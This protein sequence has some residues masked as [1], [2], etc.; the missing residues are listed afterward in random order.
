[1]AYWKIVGDPDAYEGGSDPS[2]DVTHGYLFTL[3]GEAD[4]RS[5]IRVEAAKGAGELS[6]WNARDAV[7]DVLV[8]RYPP[9]RLVMGTSGIFWPDDRCPICGRPVPFTGTSQLGADARAATFA[10]EWGK[11][12]DCDIQ[13]S[14]RLPNGAWQ[15]AA[16]QDKPAAS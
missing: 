6:A 8:D 5:A 3:Q 4:D 9:R 2:A 15:P 14:R 10:R 16:A 1:M 7:T 13:L 11:C 12:S